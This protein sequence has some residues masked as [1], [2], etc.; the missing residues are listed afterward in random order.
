MECLNNE[1]TWPAP[2]SRPPV[3]L[4]EPTN[5]QDCSE[6]I[7][8]N[9]KG[10]VVGHSDSCADAPWPTE[11][12]AYPFVADASG[13]R[14]LA[15]GIPASSIYAE[16]INDA[17]YILT[18]D[19]TPPQYTQWIHRPAHWDQ[20]ELVPLDFGVDLYALTDVP[21]PGQTLPL[22]V[23]AAGPD[24]TT[25]WQWIQVQ[26]APPGGTN[27]VTFF[28]PPANGYSGDGG[29]LVV[30]DKGDMAGFYTLTGGT[31]SAMAWTREQGL[32]DLNS[33]APVAN[34]WQMRMALGI[35]D[36]RVVVGF[37]MRGT[38]ERPFRMDLPSHTL[39]ILDGLPAP[40]DQYGAQAHAINKKG[41]IVGSAG[42]LVDPIGGF[43]LAPGRAFF[44]SE[45][46]GLVDLNTLASAPD[47]WVFAD[48]ADINDLDE[49]VGFATKGPLRRAY[50]VKVTFQ[51]PP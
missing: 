13:A 18:N 51:A 5:G 37:A 24:A 30:N 21:L 14:P 50:R 41:H 8:I 31:R 25:R 46:T 39:T 11:H 4:F 33:L 3:E 12:Q 22:L 38:I 47:G 49:V 7:E 45:G 29:A 26:L 1:C 44:Y 42:Q 32:Q 34:Q 27:V 6:A 9:V 17:G 36:A 23:G 15:V 19:E 43:H 16:A 28:P 48:A 20:P 40:Y 10:V 2:A 35:N